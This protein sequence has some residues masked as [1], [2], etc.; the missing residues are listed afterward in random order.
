MRKPELLAPAGSGE[1]LRAALRFGADAVYM[2]GKSFGA[3][4]YA[5]NAEEE[6]LLSLI[7]E[8]H[9]LGKKLFLT[10]NTLL[11]EGERRE[12]LLPMMEPLVAAGLDAAIVQDFGVLKDL[13]EAFP[14]LELH[15]S[16]QMTVQGPRSAELLRSYGVSRIVLPREFREEEIRRIADT[17]LEIEAFVH[18]ALCYSY[19]G[20]CL[21][22]SLAGGRSGNR[23]RCAGSCRLPYEVY[24]DRGEFV[25]RDKAPYVLSMKDLRSIEELP[26]LLKA[27]VYSFKIEGRMKQLEYVAG[28][29]EIYRRA[30]DRAYE[31]VLQNREEAYY[32][33]DSEMKELKNLFHRKGFIRGFL[34]E[35]NTSDMVTFLPPEKRI[36]D[37]AYLK[38]LRERNQKKKLEIRGVFTAKRGEDMML[39][40]ST[41]SPLPCS[42]LLR[43]GAV[44]EAEKRSSSEEDVRSKLLQTGESD[45]VFGDL[46]VDMEEGLF[47][48]ASLLKSLR[49]DALEL[50]R[51]EILRK[52]RSLE[53][54]FV[55]RRD[56]ELSPSPPERDTVT[57]E[58]SRSVISALPEILQKEGI[59]RVFLPFIEFSETELKEYRE[60]IRS[61]GKEAGLILPPI[62]R[63]DEERSM[64]RTDLSLYDTV[65]APGLEAYLFAKERGARHVEADAS[66]Y[67]W[68]RSSL[69]FLKEIGIWD[70]TLPFE[71]NRKEWTELL[72]LAKEEKMRPSVLVYG[73]LPMMLSA[74]CVQKNCIGCDHKNALLHLKDGGGRVFPHKSYCKTC[75]SVIY[76]CLP[77]SLLKE[78]PSLKKSGVQDIRYRATIETAEEFLKILRGETEERS[79]TAG[80]YRRGVL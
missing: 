20:Q 30:L 38:A 17:G 5:E 58:V 36:P 75:V 4:A 59:N 6:D 18:G 68:N 71:L 1:I 8:A 51:D 66:F 72:R 42:V 19:S 57:V 24:N 37:E 2:G 80:H 32:V 33:T 50:L 12:G 41:V 11:K 14:S 76:N 10:V 13:R 64:R 22:S 62:F 79:M 34:D 15:A 47:L 40:L 7:D 55:T 63:L 67:A 45:F 16:T 52:M 26:R 74:H 48:P 29:V 44:M 27:G 21:M 65:L 25:G 23:G 9:L 60:S 35:K 43:G 28:V 53:K 78:I 3:R 31:A 56:M 69:H 46:Q 77:L 39:S 54:H 49:R 61:A 73:R 70:F